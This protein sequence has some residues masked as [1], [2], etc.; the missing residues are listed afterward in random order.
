MRV[1][2]LGAWTGTIYSG[3]MA[4]KISRKYTILVNVI[5]FCIGVVIQ[6]CAAVG[7]EKH[8]LAGRFITGISHHCVPKLYETYLDY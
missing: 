8:I 4:E 3:V 6:C 1:I 2:E 5:V 7:N